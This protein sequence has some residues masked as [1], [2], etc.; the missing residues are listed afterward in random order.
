MLL[1]TSQ[2]LRRLN[3]PVSSSGSKCVVVNVVP[4]AL[5]A[6]ALSSQPALG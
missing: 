3:Q 4:N 6:G 1:D 2:L 5:L